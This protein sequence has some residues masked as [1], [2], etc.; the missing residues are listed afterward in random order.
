MDVGA[1]VVATVP[2]ADGET[3]C[4]CTSPSR[5]VCCKDRIKNLLMV[6]RGMILALHKVGQIGFQMFPLYYQLED[7]LGEST[8][9]FLH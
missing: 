8:R 1:A 7:Y 6:F 3:G 2:A 9:N 4:A 5:S